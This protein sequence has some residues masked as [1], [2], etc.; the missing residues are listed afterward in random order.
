MSW[1]RGALVC[2]LLFAALG[3]KGCQIRPLYAPSAGE[4]GPQADLPAIAVDEP[5]SRVE[6]VF[7]NALLLSLRGGG[8]SAAAR[9]SLIYRLT[10]RE[11]EFAVV[12]GERLR[13][14]A[15]PGH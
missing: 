1:P 8:D 9:Y 7:R 15:P 10:I 4:A 3:L 5:V 11:L 13:Q 14:A 2:A 6:Q 12:R